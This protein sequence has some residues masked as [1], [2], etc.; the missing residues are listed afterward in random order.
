MLCLPLLTRKMSSY[1]MDPRRRSPIY[2]CWQCSSRPN[3]RAFD[4]RLSFRAH[5][6]Y[7]HS[8]DLQKRRCPTDNGFEDVVVRLDSVELAAKKRKFQL[9]TASPAERRAIYRMEQRHYVN[10][11][12]CY[13]NP[14][15]LQISVGMQEEQDEGQEEKEEKVEGHYER[16]QTPKSSSQVWSG[17]GEED[18]EEEIRMIQ[19]QAKQQ[20]LVETMGDDEQKMKEEK[21]SSPVISDLSSEG[22]S[23][24]NSQTIIPEVGQADYIDN[25]CQYQNNAEIDWADEAT[26]VSLLPELNYS[27]EAEIN[28]PEQYRVATPVIPEAEQ[29]VADSVAVSGPDSD[30]REITDRQEEPSRTDRTDRREDVNIINSNVVDDVRHSDNI[31]TDNFERS[32]TMPTVETQLNALMQQISAETLIFQDVSVEQLADRIAANSAILANAEIRRL[33][34]MS[35]VSSRNLAINL[36]RNCKASA[37]L[38]PDANIVLASLMSE[39]LVIANRPL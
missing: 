16:Q 33:V 11:M 24:D 17:E 28:K 37:M 27:N 10:K 36:L 2:T 20:V 7:H 3:E 4:T 26:L 6:V 8:L 9:R 25:N 19:Q 38:T 21:R 5:L 18:D 30:R 23:I 35:A 13:V 39:I 14:L 31:D 1:N 15:E 34:L 12:P 22:Q 32:I 29:T